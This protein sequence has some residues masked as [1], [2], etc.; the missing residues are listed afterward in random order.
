MALRD[1][2]YDPYADT[3]GLYDDRALPRAKH[4]LR[5]RLEKNFLT[6]Q[7][8]WR[9]FVGGT[10]YE[11]SLTAKNQPTSND[12]VW[13][14][15]EAENAGQTETDRR[16]VPVEPMSLLFNGQQAFRF[17]ADLKRLFAGKPCIRAFP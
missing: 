12:E 1:Y 10:L 5:F 7:M 14:C 15:Q 8:V 17:T 16:L 6:G 3:G 9:V 13:L 4:I 2:G 11:V